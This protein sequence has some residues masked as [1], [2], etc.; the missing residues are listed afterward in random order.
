MAYQ[1]ETIKQ[2]QKIFYYLLEHHELREENEPELHKAY[3]EQDEVQT[4]VKSQAEAAESSIET[5]SGV[6]Y[7]IPEQE[8]NFLGYSKGQLKRELCRS[9]PTDKDYYLV[10]FVILVLLLEFYDGQ[11][12]SSK[13]RDFIRLG[14]LQNSITEKLKEGAARY[15]EEEQAQNS[16]A[17]TAMQQAY[18]ALKSDERGRRQKTTKE[19]FMYSILRFLQSQ[20][21]IDYIEQDE[22]IKTTRKLD[23]FMD[24]NLLNKNNFSRVQRVLG[25]EENEQN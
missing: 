2:S 15:A 3:L 8:N 10:Q 1:I 11:G 5:Y 25:A 22:M 20:G 9:N 13:T 19:G 18:E 21:L 12:S 16:F 23:N 4:L 14:E 24:W 7:L 17:F 6:I